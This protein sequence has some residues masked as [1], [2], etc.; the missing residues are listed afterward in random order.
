MQKIKTYHYKEGG[1]DFHIKRE[2]GKIGK[3]RVF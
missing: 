2:R 3:K 1:Q